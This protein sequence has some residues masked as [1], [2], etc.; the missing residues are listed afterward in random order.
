[1]LQIKLK[2]LRPLTNK[3]LE[4][5]RKENPDLRFKAEIKKGKQYILLE[6]E[7]ESNDREYRK[8]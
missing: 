4:A 5:I 6:I 3:E 8:I 2:P 7:N 1:M